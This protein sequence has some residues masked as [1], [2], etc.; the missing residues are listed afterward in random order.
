VSI[1]RLLK[2]PQT[3]A[4]PL[5]VFLLPFVTIMVTQGQSAT[6]D[7]GLRPGGPDAGGPI[8]GLSA[9]EANFFAKGIAAFDETDSVSGT[10]P[11]EHGVGLG[12]RFN[13]NQCASCHS[14]PARGGTSPASN[15][16]VAVANL[17]G[18]TNTI[19]FF[20]TSNGPVREARFKFKRSADGTL[21]TSR[22]GGVHDLFVIT[23]RIDAPGCSIAQPNFALEASQNNVIFRIPTPVFGAGLIEEIPDRVIVANLRADQAVKGALGIQGRLN[24]NGND[25]TIARFGW[26]AQNK[27]LQ[28][29]A[30]EAYN[31]EQGVTNEVFQTERDE[32]A[33]C[34]FNPTPEDATS[35]S[36][37]AVVPETV[38]SDVVMFSHFMRFLAPPTPSPDTPG[39]AASIANGRALFTSAAATGCALCHT[40]TLTTGSASS[41]ALS[42]KP[43][44]L[45]SDLAVH[46]MGPGL[47]DNIVQGQA[48]ASSFRTAPLWG[49]G[50]RIFFL[51]DGRTKDLLEAIQAHKSA[52]DLVFPPSE[53]NAVVDKF[54]ALMPDQQQDILNF[55][56]SL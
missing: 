44:N 6:A 43:A 4:L 12:P 39:G 2:H 51:H 56:R 17:D 38:P 49:L 47:A 8:P 24:R 15:P 45:F 26:K 50:K 22:D 1:T 36:T 16:Q 10:V 35:F 53:A 5:L 13:S 30:G 34:R 29:F 42:D 41:T 37:G 40:P 11:G 25:G 19:P 28:L 33:G 27:S 20:V 18:A 3:R 21:G 14:Q 32:T 9:G 23:G 7:P 54:N 55:L 46:H 48:R 31:V 52:G